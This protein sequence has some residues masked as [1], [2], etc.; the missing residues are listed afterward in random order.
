MRRQCKICCCQAL[1][2][3]STKFLESI[4][5]LFS[6]GFRGRPSHFGT[7]SRTIFRSKW[8]SP[9]RTFS[10]RNFSSAGSSASSSSH[11]SFISSSSSFAGKVAG[12]VAGLSG[13]PSTSAKPKAASAARSER[14]KAWDIHVQ[15][16]RQCIQ[17]GVLVAVKVAGH[18]GYSREAVKGM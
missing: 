4:L 2:C 3:L 17:V 12:K 5:W 14:L 18:Q 6:G 16:D 15:Q 8:R 10:K 7:E 11:S 13:P 1:C 9:P